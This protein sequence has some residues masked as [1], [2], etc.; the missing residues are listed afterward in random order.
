MQRLA[1]EFGTNLV[2]R[3]HEHGGGSTRFASLEYSANRRLCRS[4]GV[5]DRLPMVLIYSHGEL[6][7]YYPCNAKLARTTLRD[8]LEQYD[9]TRP[10]LAELKFQVQMNRGTALGNAV[11]AQLQQEERRM[12][13]ELQPSS[14]RSSKFGMNETSVATLEPSSS[15]SNGLRR[16]WPFSIS[17]SRPDRNP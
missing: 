3:G 5:V 15:R 2:D 17:S 9:C 10:S 11:V 6:I 14:I 7:D 12:K 1:L 8:Q 4:L 16:F 13:V